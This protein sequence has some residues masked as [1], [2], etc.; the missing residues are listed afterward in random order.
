MKIVKIDKKIGFFTVQSTKAEN[1]DK[2]K[3]KRKIYFSKGTGIVY[4]K[5]LRDPVVH[6]GKFSKKSRGL[7]ATIAE[8]YYNNIDW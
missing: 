1:I 3:G 8:N 5:D 4:S 7:K 2:E 6:P